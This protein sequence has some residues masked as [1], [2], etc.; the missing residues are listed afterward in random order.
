[1]GNLFCFRIVLNVLYAVFHVILYQWPR[2]I[3]QL[4]RKWR[5]RKFKQWT[6]EPSKLTNPPTTPNLA[7]LSFQV[8]Y[9]GTLLSFCFLTNTQYI[10]NRF[11]LKCEYK[12]ENTL[13]LFSLT[14]E[15]EI[16]EV[17]L[18]EYGGNDRSRKKEKRTWENICPK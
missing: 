5:L 15:I 16:E 2:I 13:N 11:I 10:I 12:T 4:V 1:M 17:R 8:P 7:I 6:M 14:F 3:V 18:G 9:V